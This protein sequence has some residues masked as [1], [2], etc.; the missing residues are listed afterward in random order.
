MTILSID[1]DSPLFGYVRPGFKILAVNGSPVVD[2]IDFHFKISEEQVKIEFEDKQ[3]GR[4]EFDFHQPSS[5]DLGLT[6]KDD[7]VQVCK[8]DCIFCF[9][10]Q[11]PKGMRESLYT[12]D[13]DYR[14]SFTH[15]N[16]I[17]LS[18]IT[19][20]EMDRIIDQRL[21]PMYVSV[22]VTDDKLR[23]CM[24]RN[25]KLAP[26]VPQLKYLTKNGISVCTQAV[27]CPEVNDG[28]YLTRT[29]CELAELYPGVQNLA[30]VPVGLTRHRKD[31]SKLRDFTRDEA[32]GIIEQIESQQRRFMD[33]LGT[34]FV[35]PADEFYVVAGKQFPRQSEYEDMAQFENGIGMVREFM[36]V[37]N[38][39]R[40]Y[41]PSFSSRPKTL[42]VTG[43]SAYGFLSK[44]VL[45]QI[46][47]T[48]GL[49]VSLHAV[50]NRFWGDTVTVSGLL[51]GQDILRELRPI[52]ANYDVLVLP[53]NCLNDDNLFLDNLTLD[54]FASVLKKR[55]LLGSYDMTVTLKEIFQ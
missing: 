25:E 37:F 32:A 31:L 2:A 47:D 14:L 28:E 7:Q 21:S 13:E 19:D 52:A 22:H 35:W 11:Q 16:F 10:Q 8:C 50:T 33:T 5:D 18:N 29:I 20:V 46:T 12:K 44:N 26:I 6:L 27:I 40:R 9:I 53:P 51:T 39:R 55:V 41:L 36:T 45:P 23:R 34:R 48:L 42:M 38:R 24:L 1:P 3:G 30:I 43:H 15:G 54:Q 4:L 49:P 17:T